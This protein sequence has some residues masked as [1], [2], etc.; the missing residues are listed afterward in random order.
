MFWINVV[1]D[2]SST[3]DD[4]FALIR[5]IRIKRLR[6]LLARTIRKGPTLHAPVR[7]SYITLLHPEKSEYNAYSSSSASS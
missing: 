6:R 2:D 7:E 5:S 3:R 1:R 4:G